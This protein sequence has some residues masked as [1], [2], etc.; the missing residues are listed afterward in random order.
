MLEKYHE[1][2]VAI[3]CDLRLGR[4]NS[5][6]VEVIKWIR[7]YEWNGLNLPEEFLRYIPIIAFSGATIGEDIHTQALQ[8]GATS[9]VV[10]KSMLISS[11]NKV[12]RN[13]RNTLKSQIN[14]FEH[15]RK[16]NNNWK[17]YYIGLSFTGHNKSDRHREFVE[18]IANQLSSKYRR[19]RVFFD[20]DKLK[21]GIT[22]SCSQ[23]KISEIYKNNCKYIIVFLSSDYNTENNLWTKEEWS[24]IFEYYKKANRNVFFVN[25]ENEVNE[26]IFKKNLGIDEVIWIPAFEEREKFYKMIDGE[27]SELDDMFNLLKV[28]KATIMEYNK[29]CIKKYKEKCTDIANGVVSII[30]K[31]ISEAEKLK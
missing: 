1:E 4:H 22:P 24:G 9:L 2:L 15:V 6:G 16:H 23:K 13:L 20:Q 18:I 25:L 29:K 12:D 30:E 7:D 21:E 14:Y 28:S 3:V 19:E 17:D 11:K 10:K 26:D 27:D 31:S 5:D 8:E